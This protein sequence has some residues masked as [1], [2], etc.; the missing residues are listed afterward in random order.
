MGTRA[1]FYVGTGKGAEWIGSVALDGYEW[2]ERID[3]DDHD[4]ITLAKT[5]TEYRKAVASMISEKNH[6][7]TP[8]HGWPW[9]WDDSRTTD[10][11]YCFDDNK[12]NAYS[13]G[14]PWNDEDAEHIE[15]PDMSMF[16]HSAKAGSKRSGI[17]LVR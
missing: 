17:I 3:R 11:A 7:T 9:P 16:E 13:W 14:A 6:G 4:A 8:E 2:G 12:V 10:C 1:D 5:E 15:W